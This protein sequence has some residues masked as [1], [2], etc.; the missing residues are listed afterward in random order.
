L[1][2]HSSTNERMIKLT[3][4]N[5]ISFYFFCATPELKNKEDI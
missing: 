2:V 5:T 3:L 1:L 4:K